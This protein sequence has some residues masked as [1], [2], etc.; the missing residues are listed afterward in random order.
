MEE[1]KTQTIK[2]M[3]KIAMSKNTTVKKI[4][5]MDYEE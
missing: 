3:M 4:F 2:E 1:R 5:L